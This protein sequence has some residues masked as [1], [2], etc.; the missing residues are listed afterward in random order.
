MSPYT[1]EKGTLPNTLDEATIA[2]DQNQTDTTQKKTVTGEY[3]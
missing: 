2:L 3:H 1:V